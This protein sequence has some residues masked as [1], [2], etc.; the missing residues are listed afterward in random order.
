MD[1][2]L[3]PGSHPYPEADLF[4]IPPE[5]DST[6]IFCKGTRRGIK[7]GLPKM[8][9]GSKCENL[10]CSKYGKTR[11][12]NS[13][14]SGRKSS[15][16]FACNVENEGGEICGA[17]KSAPGSKCTRPSCEGVTKY[18]KRKKS[19]G[20]RP[21]AE[22]PSKVDLTKVDYSSNPFSI[23]NFYGIPDEGKLKSKKKT[24]KIKKKKKTKKKKPKKRKR[25]SR[26]E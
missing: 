16:K 20:E 14:T 9:P 1:V 24:K 19:K 5:G 10:Q 18:G 2:V 6:G 12:R 17:Q 26:K 21:P 8:Y 7:C 23:E 15:G 22:G 4:E 25:S 13:Y 11:K 3:P